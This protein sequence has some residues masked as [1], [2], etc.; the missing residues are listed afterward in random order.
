[1]IKNDFAKRI[2]VT[3]GAGY[4]GSHMTHILLNC[5]FEVVVIDNLVN[6]HRDAIDERAIFVNSDI[7]N[8][9]VVLK[10][11]NEKRCSII[12]F[13]SYLEVAESMLNA[14]KYYENNV[15]KTI[16]FLDSIVKSQNVDHFIFSSSAAVYG[17]SSEFLIA[18]DSAKNPTNIYGKTKLLIEN[19]LA[20]YAAI[21][22]LSY[23][24]LRYFNACGADFKNKLGERHEPETHLIPLVLQFINKRRENF[25][26]CG[27]DY[28]TIDGTCIRDYVD[29]RDICSAHLAMLDYL[30]RGGAIRSFNIGSGAG[31]SVLEIVNKAIEITKQSFEIKFTKRRPGDSDRLVANNSSISSNLDWKPKFD[32]DSIISSAWQW[33]KIYSAK[34][35]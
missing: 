23:G 32:L 16:I 9:E 1:M 21:H 30:K 6:G 27:N 2:I 25:Y 24:C 35:I 11:L 12:H 28:N 33:E 31:Y 7:A 10:I 8:K 4:I 19:I 17:N 18:E 14:A 13:A 3:G 5:G 20:D 26:I 29:V 34:K 22:G 15:A